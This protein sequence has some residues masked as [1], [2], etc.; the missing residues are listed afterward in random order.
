MK[1]FHLDSGSRLHESV[2]GA[3]I[4]THDLLAFWLEQQEPAEIDGM[5]IVTDKLTHRISVEN[6]NIYL[7]LEKKA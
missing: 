6:N 4:E 7:I 2:D 1:V 5:R 3:I